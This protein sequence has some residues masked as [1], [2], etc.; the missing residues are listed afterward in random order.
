MGAPDDNLISRLFTARRGS[1]VTATVFALGVTL[2]PFQLVPGW[3]M[4]FGLGFSPVLYVALCGVLGLAAGAA[5]ARVGG[6]ARQAQQQVM[7]IGL[8]ELAEGLV[9]AGL[10]MVIA[11]VGGCRPLMGGSATG[12]PSRS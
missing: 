7:A 5:G 1:Y 6:P 8:Q 9:G 3:E 4:N 12:C 10:G 2:A 11:R